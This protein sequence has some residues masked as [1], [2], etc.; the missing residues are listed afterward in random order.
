MNKRMIIITA[1]LAYLLCFHCAIQAQADA[2][3]KA[4]STAM[5]NNGH[6][7]AVQYG[8]KE[9]DSTI[10]D[11]EVWIYDLENLLYPPQYLAGAIIFNTAI[12]FSP[13][14]QYIAVGTYDHLKVFNTE[15]NSLTLYLPR[16]A[17]AKHTNFH[18]FSFSQDSQYIMSFS[19]WWVTRDHEMSIWDIHTK[20]RTVT[21]AADRSQQWITRPWL[22]PDWRQFFDWSGRSMAAIYEFEVQQGLGQ[23]K[24][25][26]SRWRDT[27]AAFSPDSSLFA[28][29]TS[30][31]EVAVY[32]TDTWELSYRKT[33]P[34]GTCGGSDVYLTFGHV[35]SW[36]VYWC[37]WSGN[38]QI[39]DIETD[40]LL[41]R[42]EAN[43]M[44]LEF[45][46]DNEMLVGSYNGSPEYTTISV[47]NIKKDFELTEY[48]GQSPSLHPNGELM[49]SIGPDSRIWIW[50]IKQDQPL[51]ILP[52]P[53]NR[54]SRRFAG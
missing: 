41:F 46:L 40:E 20:R 48:P 43:A 37:N 13:D 23:E 21:V 12:A 1:L 28:L 15:D 10:Y 36:L 51:V 4:L 25:N 27:G 32:R 42:T 22:S 14:S 9:G 8:T 24:G 29:A 50:N 16:T 7:L 5:S 26:I 30:E 38:L 19:D 49:A 45:T 52:I 33:L 31:D 3:W 44:F 17:T 54:E 47:W 39:W 53:Q 34:E 2:P 11:S 6:Y 18:W 35:N